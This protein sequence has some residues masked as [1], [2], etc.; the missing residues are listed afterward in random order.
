MAAFGQRDGDCEASEAAADND[1]M[2]RTYSLAIAVGD[3]SDGER[4]RTILTKYKLYKETKSRIISD[5]YRENSRS[6]INKTA[7]SINH[8]PLAIMAVVVV[9]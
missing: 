6:R 9:H 7:F 8:F 2:L 5:I 3:M 1:D 4:V